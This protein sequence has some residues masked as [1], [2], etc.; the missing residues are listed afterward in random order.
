MIIQRQTCLQLARLAKG[1]LQNVPVQIV[2]VIRVNMIIKGLPVAALVLVLTHVQELN[3]ST[4]IAP[5]L[6][7]ISVFVK[8]G[9]I[10][11]H[12]TVATQRCRNGLMH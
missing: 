3:A 4:G 12:D 8:D 11:R 5:G 9:K 2:Q 10:A 6:G 1:F 7:L